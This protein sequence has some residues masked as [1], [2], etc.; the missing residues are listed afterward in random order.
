MDAF[1][2]LPVYEIGKGAVIDFAIAKRRDKRSCYTTKP[3]FEFIISH[4]QWSPRFGWVPT[5]APA[6]SNRWRCAKLTTGR[7]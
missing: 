1:S 2:D 3:R 4:N 6:Q 7:I 5:L